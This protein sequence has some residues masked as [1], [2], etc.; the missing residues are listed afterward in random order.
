[1]SAL[2]QLVIDPKLDVDEN[3]CILPATGPLN[4]VL[5]VRGV[6]DRMQLMQHGDRGQI[7]WTE[8]RNMKYLCLHCMALL[9]QSVIVYLIG[10]WLLSSVCA[11][12]TECYLF[13][14]PGVSVAFIVLLLLLCLRSLHSTYFK[15]YAFEVQDELA[16]VVA[17]QAAGSTFILD[18]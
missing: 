18:T 14:S 8:K 3:E 16:F 13:I 4:R 10:W 11:Q 7:L 6:R 1:M 9:V 12:I 2:F 15:K 17:R 5:Y